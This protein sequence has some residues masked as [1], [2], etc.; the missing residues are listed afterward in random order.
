MNY[1]H[2]PQGEG[3]R[4]YDQ[5]S[6]R[7]SEGNGN[8]CDVD[9]GSSQHVNDDGRCFMTGAHRGERR[10]LITVQLLTFYSKKQE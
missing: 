7:G 1:H 10:E 4:H 5:L 9:R 6:L 8:K 2:G 3:E